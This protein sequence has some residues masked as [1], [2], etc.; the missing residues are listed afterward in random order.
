MRNA[1]DHLP[2]LIKAYGKWPSYL[3]LLIATACPAIAIALAV[4]MR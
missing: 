2:A 3:Y 4:L 1:L